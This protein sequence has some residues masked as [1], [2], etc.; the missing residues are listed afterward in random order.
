MRDKLNQ[1]NIESEF[2]IGN[3]E[4]HEYWG[5][6]NGNWFGGPN[7]NYEQIKNDSYNFLYNLLDVTQNVDINNDG[8]INILDIVSVVN[9]ILNN[10]YDYIADMN[11]DG[12]LDILDI[13][14]IVNMV[15]GRL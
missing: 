12:L 7:D 1:L 3:G 6:L 2:Y 5:T 11:E 15:I 10:E 9:M 14:S 13:V 8:V 4:L